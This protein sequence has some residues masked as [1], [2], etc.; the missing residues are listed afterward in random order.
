MKP[1]FFFLIKKN[2]QFIPL[3]R[4]KNPIF[5]APTSQIKKKG[6]KFGDFE[7]TIFT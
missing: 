6:G 4:K 5:A 3:Q 2:P 7:H 1:A